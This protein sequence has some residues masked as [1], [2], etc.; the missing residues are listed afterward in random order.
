MRPS[1]DAEVPA[2]WA[3]RAVRAVHIYTRKVRKTSCFRVNKYS[4]SAGN[5]VPVERPSSSAL[6]L[7]FLLVTVYV[8]EQETRRSL[9][10]MPLKVQLPYGP[11]PFGSV[12]KGSLQPSQRAL[13]EDVAGV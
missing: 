11:A 5:T 1:R 9:G 4:K 6:S 12:V 10:L 8:R 2:D 7:L 3:V 13:E